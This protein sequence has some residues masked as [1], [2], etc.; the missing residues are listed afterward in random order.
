[1]QGKTGKMPIFW[2]SSWNFFFELN[3][4]GH[5]PS[6]KSFSSARTHH[7]LI[8]LI[9]LQKFNPFLYNL[10]K[11]P[12]KQTCFQ[13]MSEVKA[14]SNIWNN[15]AQNLANSESCSILKLF[16]GAKIR[17]L[18]KKWTCLCN[19]ETNQWNEPNH[20]THSKGATGI[21]PKWKICSVQFYGVFRPC[22]KRS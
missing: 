6:W 19:S 4:K 15:L 1:M 10:N 7:Y 13:G 22:L 11:I 3:E 20:S 18:S 5:E 16:Q 9:I 17:N 2:F 14:W 21:L 8:T 12:S